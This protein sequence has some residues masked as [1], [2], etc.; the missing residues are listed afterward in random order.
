MIYAIIAGAL[1]VLWFV[2]YVLFKLRELNGKYEYALRRCNE[3][4]TDYNRC[5]NRVYGLARAFG[6]ERVDPNG[7]VKKSDE[8]KK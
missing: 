2:T 5:D 8:V 6:Y 4:Q 3:T 7:W 1:T